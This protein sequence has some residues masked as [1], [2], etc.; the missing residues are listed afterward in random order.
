[1]F[2]YLVTLSQISCVGRK[3][4][5][6]K[7]SRPGEDAR[8]VRA[9]GWRGPCLRPGPPGLPAHRGAFAPATPTAPHRPQ[10]FLTSRLLSRGRCARQRRPVPSCSFLPP[11]TAFQRRVQGLHP[12]G[13]LAWPLRAVITSCL[14]LGPQS[15]PPAT[16]AALRQLSLP[17]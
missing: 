16:P 17:S 7:Y 14:T 8:G 11:N 9:A 10:S 15:P 5:Y 2:P 12:P 6:R 4:V 13:S 1:M 3:R